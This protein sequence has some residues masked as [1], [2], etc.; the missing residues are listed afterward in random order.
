[1]PVGDFSL[2]G[3]RIRLCFFPFFF[4]SFSSCFS[5]LAPFLFVFLLLFS[6]WPF[7]S[8]P[9]PSF[10]F[11]CPFSSPPPAVLSAS[12]LSA[13]SPSLSRPVF[14]SLCCSPS[15]S[16]PRSC[17]HSLSHSRPS[18]S[19]RSLPRSHFPPL[20]G[21]QTHFFVA[22]VRNRS[23]TRSR[24]SEACARAPWKRPSFCRPF[25]DAKNGTQKAKPHYAASRFVTHF[26]CQKMDVKMGSASFW[27]PPRCR[28]RVRQADSKT[29]P[30]VN[31][32]HLASSTVGPLSE[33]TWLRR[34]RH[35]LVC[36]AV[37]LDG[38]LAGGA[39]RATPR[40][41]RPGGLCS[42]WGR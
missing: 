42:R 26:S 11:T 35:G 15:P 22:V 37:A 30:H 28:S 25:S 8:L 3:A 1:M 9:L 7:W 17:S 21:N 27:R 4:F 19:F 31:L 41:A 32:M 14:L 10:L 6:P 13:L 39:P 24:S 36:G 5:P 12:L 29:D 33:N 2:L 34:R 16:R 18:L 40:P 20:P 38:A 23:S